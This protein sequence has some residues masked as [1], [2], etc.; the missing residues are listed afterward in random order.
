[1]AG[2]LNHKDDL[3]TS[4]SFFKNEVEKFVKKR[5][6]IKF[7][8]PKN[9]IQ[10]ISI[11]VAELSELFLFKELNTADVLKDKN[12]LSK[13]NDEVADIFI[14]LVSF[15]NRLNIDLTQIF[16]QKMEKNQTKYPLEEFED[17]IYY[18]K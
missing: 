4:I 9:L 13:V 14:Y 12:L 2:S 16:I 6:W 7:H 1:M 11:E 15:I 10:A 5:N 8:T 17:G 3:S 18:K